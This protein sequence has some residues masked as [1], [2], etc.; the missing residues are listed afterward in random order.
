VIA[1]AP[2]KLVLSGSYSV[3]WGA[4]AI[5]TA[6]DRFAVADARRPAE[7][8]ADE[9]NAAVRLGFIDRACFVDASALRAPLP[10]GGS[11]KLGLGS[12]AAILLAT[13]LAVAGSTGAEPSRARL[14]AQA[15]EAH[16][17]AQGGGSGIDVAASTFGG[18]LRFAAP[19]PSSDRAALPEVAAHALP[20]GL[21]FAVFACD[22]PALTSS[23]VGAVRA[24][25]GAEPRR[26]EPLLGRAAEGSERA[27]S[28]GAAREMIAALEAQWAALG[29]I[30]EA[31]GAPI[32]TAALR[33]LAELARREGAC[34]VPSGAGGGDIALFVGEAP[35][36]EPL[37]AA[38]R[39]D[40]MQPLA[41][42]LG[43]AGATTV[44]E[45]SS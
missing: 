17:A 25:A 23:L 21:V 9:V 26:F 10:G 13:L 32:V 40:L 45:A 38:A 16:R 36:S 27:A 6:V 2:G 7:H 3:L 44:A 39:A 14:F 8:V 5:V 33:R 24:F 30:G 29:E 31:A 34:F 12:S 42:A 19:P 1:R 41:L 15:L 18:T 4:P 37:M 35:P 20:P 22:T 11:R 43:A 28:A